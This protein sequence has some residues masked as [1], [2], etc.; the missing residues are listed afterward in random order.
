MIHCTCILDS[1][2]VLKKSEILQIYQWSGCVKKIIVHMMF[3]LFNTCCCIDA[4]DLKN[5]EQKIQNL[6]PVSTLILNKKRTR[7][8]T[9]W[10]KV[11]C[12]QHT[13]HNLIPCTMF[14]EAYTRPTHWS[15][16]NSWTLYTYIQC[17]L[18]YH[19]QQVKA[20]VIIIL[21]KMY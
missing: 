15:C 8:I 9:G 7:K 19:V 14:L 1:L 13:A 4:C 12:K 10:L 17:I 21:K 11:I 5:E 18:A 2:H 20:V 3:Y 6:N 16:G